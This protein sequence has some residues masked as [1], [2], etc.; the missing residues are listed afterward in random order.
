[1]FGSIFI[2]DD[3]AVEKIEGVEKKAESASGKL[4]GMITTA[5]KWGAGIVTATAAAA[6]GLVAF[7]SKTSAVA[8]EIDKMSIRTGI[9]MDRLQELRYIS[10]QVGVSFDSIESAVSRMTMSMSSADEEG[11]AMAEAFAQIGIQTRNAD[12]SLRETQSVFDETIRALGDMENETERNALAFQIFGRGATELIPLFAAG[13]EGLDDLANKAHE[14]GLVMSDE[15][16]KANVEFADTLDSVK[17]AGGAVF[18]QIGT[19]L[20][21]VIM[22]FL[23]WV[24]DNMPMFQAIMSTVFT[25]VGAYV[26]FFITDL[27]P[28][29]IAIFQTAAEVITAIWQVWGGDIGGTTSNLFD[30]LVTIIQ[31]ALLIIQGLIQVFG[32]IVTGDFTMLKEGLSKIWEALWNTVKAI[33]RTAVDLLKGAFS[34]LRDALFSI[35]DAIWSKINSI[36]ERIKSAV[37]TVVDTVKKVI[38]TIDKFNPFGGGG[39]PSPGG[40]GSPGGP[41][42]YQGLATGGKVEE[43]GMFRVGEIGPEDVFLPA[44]AAVVPNG[45]MGGNVVFERGAFDGAI[46]AD[47]YG[48][49]RLMDRVIERLQGLGLK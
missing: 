34:N 29:L 5:A 44:G 27:M 26:G 33:A 48:V 21:P 9:S 10:G 1:M 24:L 3:E 16:I 25:A 36:V 11:K 43:A 45:G 23:S 4:G 30:L 41:S 18:M 35:W 20:L 7:V 40:G 14:L 37:S 39:N 19:E 13:S 15:A 42:G 12:G 2:K 46:I 28:G 38:D 32:G 31:S 49:D 6:G 22:F 17:Q 8:D 47:D